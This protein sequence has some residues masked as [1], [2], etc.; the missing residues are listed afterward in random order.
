MTIAVQSSVGTHAFSV[1]VFGLRAFSSVKSVMDGCGHLEGF[2][3][4]R[5]SLVQEAKA[6]AVVSRSPVEEL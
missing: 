4:H 3:R 5:N 6:G 2:G 1:D